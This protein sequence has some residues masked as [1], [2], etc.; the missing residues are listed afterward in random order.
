MH[1]VPAPDRVR[2][3]ED[4][5]AQPDK[6][7]HFANVMR[8]SPAILKHVIQCVMIVHNVQV[9][10]MAKQVLEQWKFGERILNI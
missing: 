6:L 9:V 10:A 7:K 1:Q 3:A 5:S 4:K 2:R 8:T